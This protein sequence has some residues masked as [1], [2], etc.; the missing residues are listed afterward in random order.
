MLGEPLTLSTCNPMT[1]NR[2]H[3]GCSTYLVRKVG[4]NA[5]KEHQQ[6]EKELTD[7]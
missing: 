1:A 2:Q 7:T 3:L 6:E 4:R 5:G